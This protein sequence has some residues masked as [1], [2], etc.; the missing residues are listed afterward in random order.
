MGVGMFP[1]MCENKNKITIK[2]LKLKTKIITYEVADS[3]DPT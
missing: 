3:N 1:H 2:K